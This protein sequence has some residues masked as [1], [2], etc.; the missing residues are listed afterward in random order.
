MTQFVER[1]KSYLY[2]LRIQTVLTVRSFSEEKQQG[3]R[4]IIMLSIL[5]PKRISRMTTLS[6][7]L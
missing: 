6:R 4:L 1:K 7:M 2:P 3:T 5:V